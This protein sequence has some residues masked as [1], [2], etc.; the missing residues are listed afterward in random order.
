[1]ACVF[2]AILK[3]LV[4]K[5]NRRTATT[6]AGTLWVYPIRASDRVFKAYPTVRGTRLLYLETSQPEIGSPSKE[7]MGMARRILPSSASLNSKAVFIVGI[8]D[9][10][11]EKLKPDR[12]KAKLRNTRCLVLEIMGLNYNFPNN[13]NVYTFIPRNTVREIKTGNTLLLKKRKI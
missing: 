7:P 11:V 1:M 13:S 10:Q 8:L 4:V 3:I 9:A 6:N 12:K 5:E 2:T